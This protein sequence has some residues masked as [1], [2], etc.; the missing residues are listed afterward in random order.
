MFVE[1]RKLQIHS[2]YSNSNNQLV[3]PGTFP[4]DRCWNL[5]G[6]FKR[7]FDRRAGLT[8]NNTIG[9]FSGGRADLFNS[10]VERSDLPA[11]NSMVIGF[12]LFRL[13]NFVLH[14]E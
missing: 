6:Y 5:V 11:L 2:R 10:Y 12:C 8:I 7:V 9:R 4:R 3:M 1:G 13:V 14:F